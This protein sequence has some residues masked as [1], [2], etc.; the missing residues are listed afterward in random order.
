MANQFHFR[1]VR[2]T[3]K[4]QLLASMSVSLSVCP[5]A[6]M[7]QLGSHMMG[8]HEIPYFSIFRKSVKKINVSL[9]SDD[10]GTAHEYQ[11]IFLISCSVFLRMR[12]VSHRSHKEIWNTHFVF[13]N[14]FFKNLDTYEIMWK[15]SVQLV[16]P[17]ITTWGLRTACRITT[18]TNTI[19]DY[20]TL[21]PLN[22]E[23]NP[24]CQ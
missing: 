16:R 18:A 11:H 8:F 1:H 13:K 22:T 14:F 10:N 24:I 12:Y 4:K 20:V 7:E 2:K 5:S 3:T 23:L 6:S 17:Q 21:N 15:N 9:K 19:S